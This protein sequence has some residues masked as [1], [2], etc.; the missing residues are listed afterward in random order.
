VTRKLA[1]GSTRDSKWQEEEYR[2]LMGEDALERQELAAKADRGACTC[3]RRTLR[4]RGGY[5]TIHQRECVKYKPW[6]EDHL[7]RANEKAA[8]FVK[9]AKQ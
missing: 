1:P 5:R 9:S 7:A 8:A 4:T 6:M 3:A 2:R